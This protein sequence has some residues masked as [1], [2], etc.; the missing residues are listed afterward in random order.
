MPSRTYHSGF[1][2]PS[3]QALISNILVSDGD[4]AITDW[5]EGR[6]GSVHF[7]ARTPAS[8][9]T[10]GSL[11][12]FSFEAS[13]PPVAGKVALSGRGLSEDVLV[14]LLVPGVDPN[15][16]LIDDFE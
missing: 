3:N 10:W 6:G 9:L 15:N 8:E 5:A 12:S 13:T 1:S 7:R 4:D 2:V 14:D 11:Y 16:L